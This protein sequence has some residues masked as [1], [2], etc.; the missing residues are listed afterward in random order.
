MANKK[1]I[2][3]ITNELPSHYAGRLGLSY[4]KSVNQEHKKINGQ[5]FTPVEIAVS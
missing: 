4:A 3:Q 2:G 1:L 5:F